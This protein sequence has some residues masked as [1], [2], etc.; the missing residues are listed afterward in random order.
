[1]SDRIRSFAA[2]AAPTFVTAGFAGAVFATL[3]GIATALGLPEATSA[4]TGVVG[5]VLTAGATAGLAAL[6]TAASYVFIKPRRFDGRSGLAGFFSGLAAAGAL[7]YAL[8]SVEPAK[9]SSVDAAPPDAAN[10][11]VLRNNTGAA[12]GF[13]T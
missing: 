4:A 7:T 3:S 2:V 6:T 10:V 12:P 9:K 11:L 13:T 1:M 8:A 5:T